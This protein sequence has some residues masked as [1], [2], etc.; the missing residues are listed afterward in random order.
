[1]PVLVHTHSP[2]RGAARSRQ[3]DYVDFLCRLHARGVL[4]CDPSCLELDLSDEDVRYT[5]DAEPGM[6]DKVCCLNVLA[7]PPG[8]VVRFLDLY[9]APGMDV[10]YSMLLNSFGLGLRV[11]VTGV[12]VVRDEC[13][14]E[15]FER[16]RR[17][18]EAVRA[19]PCNCE[20][21][22]VQSSAQDFCRSYRGPPPDVALISMPWMTSLG[23]MGGSAGSLR[24]PADMLREA[25]ALLGSLER[26][27]TPPRVVSLMVPFESAGALASGYGV[28]ESV[29]VTKCSAKS[30]R[31][32]SEYYCHLLERHYSGPA[33][34]SEF[35]FS[36]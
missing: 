31:K 3:K 17:N 23:E 15:R 16:M 29:L 20:V 6:Y 33:Q 11:E 25:R 21:T 4:G 10:V 28:R 12:S 26:S 30:G 34:A 22:L 19:L 13:D 24:E 32:I 9:A 5:T 36:V 1:M 27:G 7:P 18:V 2:H 8:S 14:L 35:R